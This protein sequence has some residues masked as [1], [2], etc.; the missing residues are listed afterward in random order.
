MVSDW[1]LNIALTYCPRAGVFWICCALLLTAYSC[2][3]VVLR[4]PLFGE[5]IVAAAEF[6]GNSF[7]WIW[8]TYF[9][10]ECCSDVG[11]LLWSDLKRVTLSWRLPTMPFAKVVYFW[12]EVMALP[13][14]EV[15]PP[16]K[17]LLGFPGC[18]RPLAWIIGY[19]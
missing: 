14:C 12:T 18:Y 19:T 6:N 8:E 17:W 13:L 10:W 1:L 5:E 3:E 7:G 9:T 16:A 4:V 2:W 15:Y 11:S